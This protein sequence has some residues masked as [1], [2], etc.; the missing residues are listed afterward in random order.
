MKNFSL[1][2][3]DQEWFVLTQLNFKPNGFFVD[4]GA[5]DGVHHSNTFLLE[6]E[7]NWKGILADPA[8]I[9]QPMLKANRKNFI[10][11]DYIWKKTGD[12]LMFNEIGDYST[13]DKYIDSDQ[14]AEIRKGL[15]KEEGKRYKVITLSLGD[16][17]KKYNAPST[18]DYL[19]IDTEGSEYEILKAFNFTKYKFNIITCEHNHTPNREKIYELLV[20][21]G[22]K[23]KSTEKSKQD[24]WYIKQ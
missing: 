24:D 4:V 10:E 18:I 21:N 1:S 8:K 9:W 22:Y 7:Y 17:L 5:N 3:N 16:L 19:S 13:I 6:K 14:H 23:R 15:K 20:K 2:S 11:T 12:T